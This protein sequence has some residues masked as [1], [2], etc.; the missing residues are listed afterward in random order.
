MAS[1]YQSIIKFVKKVQRKKASI[2]WSLSSKWI[3]VNGFGNIDLLSDY[4][5]EKPKDQRRIKFAKNAEKNE[6]K[7]E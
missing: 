2:P 4:F 1:Q 7:V 5:M 3:F 6:S